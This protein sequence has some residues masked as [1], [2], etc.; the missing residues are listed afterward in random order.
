MA[1]ARTFVFRYEGHSA[2]DEEWTDFAGNLPIPAVSDLLY[3]QGRTWTVT[4]VIASSRRIIPVY[5]VF[6]ADNTRRSL[7]VVNYTVLEWQKSWADARIWQWNEAI[8]EA[9]VLGDTASMARSS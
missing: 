5:Q 6:L 7:R 3:R 4:R 1:D 8:A 9:V 2:A